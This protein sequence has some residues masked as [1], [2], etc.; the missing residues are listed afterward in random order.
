MLRIALI[1]IAPDSMKLESMREGKPIAESSHQEICVGE[2]NRVTKWGGSGL[3][4]KK[5]AIM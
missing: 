3:Q 4:E 1:L 2:A 5:V